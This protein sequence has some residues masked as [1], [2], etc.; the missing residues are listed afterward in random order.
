MWK[1]EWERTVGER[2]KTVRERKQLERESNRKRDWEQMSKFWAVYNL[3]KCKTALGSSPFLDIRLIVLQNLFSE[4]PTD[5]TAA[6]NQQFFTEKGSTFAEKKSFTYLQRKNKTLF[7]F[8]LLLLEI[9]QPL[10][11]HLK[12]ET[13]LGHSV[14]EF[15]FLQFDIDQRGDEIQL[16]VRM[17]KSKH[18]NK[19]QY[20]L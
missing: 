4:I 11:V 13:F 16:L 3:S 1:R 19:Y 8:F 5:E 15:L 6:C 10:K 17:E 20:F 12:D 14:L 7:T 2:K 9:L 18:S